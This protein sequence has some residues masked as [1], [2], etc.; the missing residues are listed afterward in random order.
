MW[1][2]GNKAWPGIEWRGSNK[3]EKRNRPKWLPII[4]LFFF[5]FF[6]PT[7]RSQG[8]AVLSFSS[9]ASRF[10]YDPSNDRRRRSRNDPLGLTKEKKSIHPPSASR[11]YIDGRHPGRQPP[12]SPRQI[13]LDPND[14]CVS[15]QRGG[16][17]GSHFCPPRQPT[18]NER[19]RC[20]WPCFLIPHPILAAAAA[21]A[22]GHTGRD[23]ISAKPLIF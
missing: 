16:D 10:S 13:P 14:Y 15:I 7:A 4:F 6:L 22:L 19:G 2:L 17:C 8:A 18:G 21:A 11:G 1:D 12:Q 3:G 9:P 20:C 5:L 23:E